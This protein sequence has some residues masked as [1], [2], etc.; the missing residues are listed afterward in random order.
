MKVSRKTHKAFLF[1]PA[2]LMLFGAVWLVAKV[3][4]EMALRSDPV[5]LSL[6]AEK[7]AA[8][9]PA[10]V[11]RVRREYHPGGGVKSVFR[12]SDGR[13]HGKAFHFYPGGDLRKVEA[14]DHGVRCGSFA[15]FYD[16]GG[17]RSKGVMHG[18]RLHGE[19]TFF[20]PDRTVTYVEFFENGM[21]VGRRYH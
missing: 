14:Y 20:A 15:T 6:G 18:G 9:R 2:V 8:H 16:G 12:M 21:S 5:P 11:C 4:G 13:R 7:A 19:V 1:L 10:A 17:L 3:Q